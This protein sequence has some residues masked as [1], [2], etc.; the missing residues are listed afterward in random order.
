MGFP[1]GP[2]QATP[3][4]GG[5]STRRPCELVSGELAGFC[6]FHVPFQVHIDCES[7]SSSSWWV[8]SH[9]AWAPPRPDG[10]G[11]ATGVGWAVGAA[12]GGAGVG[13]VAGVGR[14]PVSRE[15]SPKPPPPPPTIPPRAAPPTR[16]PRA[17]AQPGGEGAGGPDA[18]P[19]G[20]RARR[21]RGRG[22]RRRGGGRPAGQA[23][24][25]PPRPPHQ[26][27]PQPGPG[28]LAQVRGVVLA[29]AQ[30]MEE[31]V[32]GQV[33]AGGGVAGEHGAERR[34]AAVLACVHLADPL[35][36]G[37]ARALGRGGQLLHVDQ[38]VV[39][40]VPFRVPLP[41]GAPFPLGACASRPSTLHS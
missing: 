38:T 19:R 40:S 24:A 32:V 33:L 31:H 23:P 27:E 16:R 21:R 17:P 29:A 14:C 35:L 3:C 34:Q 25:A 30:G 9:T 22:G 37:L 39:P 36:R 18:T 11:S 1:S 10:A 26:G 5:M 41:L 20:A 6:C 15:C 12:V 13:V 2:S 8:L 7:S 4:S 28:R